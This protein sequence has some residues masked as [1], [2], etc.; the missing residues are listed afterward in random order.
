MVVL[1]YKLVLNWREHFSFT[2]I[3][4]SS[5]VSTHELH[6]IKV[7]LTTVIA[8]IPVLYHIQGRLARHQVIL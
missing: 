1:H 8:E 3:I 5:L 4:R 2:V 6:L 7:D